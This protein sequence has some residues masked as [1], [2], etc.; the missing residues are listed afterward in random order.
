M[1]QMAGGVGDMGNSLK[2]E[3]LYQQGGA[4][5]KQGDRRQKDGVGHFIQQKAQDAF[6]GR[7][8]NCQRPQDKSQ[9]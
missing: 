3:S 6:R 8:E 7:S 9:N 2:Q 5:G 4:E 1:K